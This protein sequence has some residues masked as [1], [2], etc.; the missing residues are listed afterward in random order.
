MA[1]RKFWLHEMLCVGQVVQRKIFNE[2]LER[3]LR[4]NS[5]YLANLESRLQHEIVKAAPLLSANLDAL[6]TAQLQQLVNAQEEALKRARAM[7]V[8]TPCQSP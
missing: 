6:P 2:N 4:G 8:S 5:Q 7:L 3:K 1:G